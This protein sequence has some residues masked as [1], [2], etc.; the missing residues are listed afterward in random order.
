MAAREARSHSQSTIKEL[1]RLVAGKPPTGTTCGGWTLASLTGGRPARS[2][3]KDRLMPLDSSLVGTSSDLV[4]AEVDVASSFC[5]PDGAAFR[6]AR[7]AR[8]TPR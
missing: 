1:G 4:S 8:L 2:R 6:A 5:A 3:R 7:R